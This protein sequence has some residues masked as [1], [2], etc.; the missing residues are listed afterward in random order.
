MWVTWW[1]RLLESAENCNICAPLK[2]LKRKHSPVSWPTKT[3]LW[4]RLIQ[5]YGLSIDFDPWVAKILSSKPQGRRCRLWP[6]MPSC[7]S[8]SV[9]RLLTHP[10]F[11]LPTC[12]MKIMDVSYMS[13][14]LFK[15]RQWEIIFLNP[16]MFSKKYINSKGLVTMLSNMDT[17]WWW[18]LKGV[19]YYTTT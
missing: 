9:G 11:Y 15:W 13:D 14:I 12:K 17:M 3:C 1:E 7:S 19:S 16:P 4:A 2:V 5:A 6:F 8:I 18:F 10:S